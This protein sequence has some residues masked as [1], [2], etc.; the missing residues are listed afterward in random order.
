MSINLGELI[1]IILS[2]TVI[3]SLGSTLLSYV[4][5]KRKYRAET[6]RT[7]TETDNLRTETEITLSEYWKNEAHNFKDEL[8]KVNAK[9]DQLIAENKD[10]KEKFSEEEEKRLHCIEEIKS[11]QS[12]IDILKNKSKEEN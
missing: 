11:M 1:V 5:Q 10:I 3:G 4:L 6:I 2:S 9:L 12:E 8:I 7:T